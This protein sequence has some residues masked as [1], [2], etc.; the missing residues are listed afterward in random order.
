MKSQTS[1]LKSKNPRFAAARLAFVALAACACAG[2]LV[3]SGAGERRTTAQP[4]PTRIRDVQGA[5]HVSP[6]AGRRVEGVPGVVTLLRPDGFFMQDAEADRDPRTSEGL[7]VR[8][9][10]PP[11]A[12]PG[13]AVKVTGTV[14]EFRQG[15][16]DASNAN[17]SA[18]HIKASSISLVSIGNPLPAPV[19]IGAGGRT[20]PAS[21]IEDDAASGDVETSGT[22]DPASD[23]LDF[24]ES[25]EGMRVR[26]DDAVAVGPTFARRDGR[27]VPVL[28]DGGAG[29]SL[30]TPR[31]GIIL[32]PTDANPE[33]VSLFADGES[34]PEVNVGARFEGRATGVVDYFA[35]G[36]KVIL[37]GV[38]PRVAPGSLQ[39][40][41]TRPA[42][43]GQLTVAGF[44]VENLDPTDDP[45]K[46]RRLARM[47]V[48]NLRAPDLLSV[49]EIQDNNGS[50]D[51]SVTDASE[52]FAKLIDAIREAGGPRYE[53]RDIAPEDDR[54]GGERGGNIRTGFLFRTDRGLRFVDRPGGDA[55]T[56]VR[57]AGGQGSP[58]LSFSPG[59][60]EPTSAVW[61]ASRKPLAGEFTFRGQRLFVVANHFN[62][63]G[64]DQP[65]YGRF[66]PPKLVSETK[67]TGQAR[68]V[69]SFVREI[70]MRDR[71]A[72]VVVLGDL[73]DYEFS[74]PLRVLKEAGL[75]VLTERLAPAERY[76]YVF[77]GNSQALDHVLVSPSLLRALASYD[78]V[79]LNSEFAD[80]ASDHDPTVA[81]FAL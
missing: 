7:F 14:M 74:A 41:V 79:H 47:V 33:R 78:V 39:P 5:S 65:P 19:T 22:F 27:E 36:Y 63:K 9:E 17:L 25:L 72:K 58:R 46:F 4:T 51:D 16:A 49:E 80:A 11:D 61:E 45:S 20:P 57:V 3:A 76:T 77:D 42:R 12:R 10:R 66:Q 6:F 24:Y 30:R 64:G 71:R 52:T 53:F 59:R 8:S 21:V 81:V 2:A 40:E 56:P 26:V 75:S 67:R 35:G 48:R 73:N 38:M 50:R 69:A 44:N 43:A 29:A 37:S 15:A 32:R 34:L 13:Y 68:A 23:G 62:S 1:S 28:P 60:V 31:G 54:D 55:T 18:T 70:F